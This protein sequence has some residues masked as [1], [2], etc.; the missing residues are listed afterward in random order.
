MS[1]H[2]ADVEYISEGPFLGTHTPSLF[3]DCVT[4]KDYIDTHSLATGVALGRRYQRR[5]ALAN[6]MTKF[7][8]AQEVKGG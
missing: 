4:G 6:I 8:C 7:G 2:I 1:C 3:A 5:K